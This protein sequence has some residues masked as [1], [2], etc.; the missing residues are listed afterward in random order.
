MPLAADADDAAAKLICSSCIGEA[1]LKAEVRRE[2]VTATCDYCNT[3]GPTISIGAFADLT[4]AVFDTY[5]ERTVNEP[6]GVDAITHNDPEGGYSW[7]REGDPASDLIQ[8]FA[9]VGDEPAND[10]CMVLEDR[11]NSP[12]DWNEEQEYGEDACYANK[13]IFAERFLFKWLE[14]ERSLRAEA[15]LFNTLLRPQ[16]ENPWAR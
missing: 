13:A 11:H 8:E 2:G 7:E 3:E 9:G 1:Y 16:P 6:E 5:F 15:R 12:D 10:T 14:F 4:H